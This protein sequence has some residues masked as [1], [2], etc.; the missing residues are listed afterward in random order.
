MRDKGHRRRENLYG[1]FTCGRYMRIV[2]TN[3][4]VISCIVGIPNIPHVHMGTPNTYHVVM[5]G[6]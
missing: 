3:D 2:R 6:N 4:E 1:K 5:M